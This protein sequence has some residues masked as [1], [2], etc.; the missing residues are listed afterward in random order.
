MDLKSW[1]W[2]AGGRGVNEWSRA[3]SL[4]FTGKKFKESTGCFIHGVPKRNFINDFHIFLVA[5]FG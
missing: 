3:D 4:T 2:G 5:K 1:L